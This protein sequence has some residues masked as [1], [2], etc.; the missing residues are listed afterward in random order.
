MGD[1]LWMLVGEG[2]QVTG[3][4]L[5]DSMPKR[6]AITVTKKDKEAG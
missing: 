3:R 2:T 4:H 6:P 1:I 5:E